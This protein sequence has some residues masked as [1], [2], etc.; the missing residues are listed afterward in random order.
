MKQE[1]QASSLQRNFALDTAFAVKLPFL[2]HILH[3]PLMTGTPSS[4]FIRFGSDD[5]TLQEIRQGSLWKWGTPKEIWIIN[6]AAQSGK[7]LKVLMGGEGVEL[8]GAN[9]DYSQLVNSSSAVIDPATEGKQD[10]LITAVGALQT[11]TETL[12]DVINAVDLL[13]ADTPTLYNVTITN[14]DTEYSQAL[15]ANTKR[16]AVHL[17]DYT[18][19]RAAFVTGKVAGPAAP[20]LTVVA[21]AELYED[22]LDVTGLTL[23]IAAPAGT[24]VAEIEVWT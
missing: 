20:F 10:N 15:P 16:F 9:V 4:T 13:K 6:A 14:A 1:V 18:A 23:Y 3:I 7:E 2:A 5:T 24:K 12:Q 22:K 8:E 21:G 19:F 17:R 11:A